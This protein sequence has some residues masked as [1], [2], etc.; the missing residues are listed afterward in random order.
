MTRH[1]YDPGTKALFSWEREFRFEGLADSAPEGSFLVSGDPETRVLQ[2]LAGCMFL[3]GCGDGCLA[4]RME[5]PDE[6]VMGLM[7]RFRGR[8][9]P[10]RGGLGSLAEVVPRDWTVC[11]CGLAAR[12]PG[13]VARFCRAVPCRRTYVCPLVDELAAFG[14]LVMR[15][16]EERPRRAWLYAPDERPAG[17]EF[18]EFDPKLEGDGY[19]RMADLVRRGMPVLNEMMS[20][21]G[22]VPFYGKVLTDGLQ[23]A[24]VY[25]V[26]SQEV[27]DFFPVEPLAATYAAMCVPV[28]V[29]NTAEFAKASGWRG[30]W[31]DVAA[32]SDA[33]PGVAAF[34]RFYKV[35]SGRGFFGVSDPKEVSIARRKAPVFRHNRA[36]RVGLDGLGRFDAEGLLQA[37]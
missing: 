17:D 30:D 12:D 11:V 16:P 33:V 24:S 3:S 9:V 5:D 36:Y 26:R 15:L 35:M 25:V 18:V 28:R 6:E 10:F 13:K 1:G 2:E 23:G 29:G 8:V 20:G 4:A 37:R 21:P 19:G 7:G 31:V 14:A 32:A 27:A 22:L 34:A